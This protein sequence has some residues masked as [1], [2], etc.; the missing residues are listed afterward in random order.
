[1]SEHPS[2][3]STKGC[4]KTCVMA[5]DDAFTESGEP[6]SRLYVIGTGVRKDGTRPIAW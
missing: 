1:M 5:N 6:A 4:R 2:P 3:L